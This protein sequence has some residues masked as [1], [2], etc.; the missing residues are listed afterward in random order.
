MARFDDTV[1]LVTG[2]TSG[3]DLPTPCI[4]RTKRPFTI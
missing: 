2:G 3:M 1:V 4:P